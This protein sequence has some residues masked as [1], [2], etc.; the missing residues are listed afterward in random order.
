MWQI[1]QN[2]LFW[3]PIDQ[4]F[5]ANRHFLR[6]Y[7][8]TD[9]KNLIIAML[10]VSLLGC[11]DDAKKASS[12]NVASNNTTA[13]NT[14]ANNTTA[15][16][17]TANN[18]TANNTTANNTTANNVVVTTLDLGTDTDPVSSVD[19]TTACEKTQ[20][21]FV[22]NLS[23][24]NLK[25]FGCLLTGAFTAALSELSTD[26]EIQ[27]ACDEAYAACLAEPAD[28][29]PF[30]ESCDLTPTDCAADIGLVEDCIEQQI[31]GINAVATTFTCADM[32]VDSDPSSEL[33]PTPT[34]C[35]QLETEC[36]DFFGAGE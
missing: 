30:T 35:D 4:I 3:T 12:N 21:Y 14:T 20:A 29:N 18:T 11:G 34:A 26:S 28:P 32:T 31:A 25:E 36:P 6:I 7:W 8:R 33:A 9:M 16:N 17:T 19:V 13:N 2:A 10:A 15:N 24:A 5:L 27:A 22:A 23:E 1:P